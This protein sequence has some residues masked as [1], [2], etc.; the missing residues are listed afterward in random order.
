M[1]FINPK[2]SLGQHFLKD[3]N[4]AT[5]IINSIKYSDYPILEIGPGLGILTEG[6]IKNKFDLSVIEIDSKVIPL[7]EKKFPSLKNKIFHGDFLKFS[8]AKIYN[9]TYSIIGNFPYNI[10]SQ[11]FF[12]IYDNRNNIK[13]VVCMVQKEVAER[14]CSP[15]GSKKYGILSVLLQAFYNI[16]YLFTVSEKVFNPPPKVKS[17]VI[18]LERNKN[19]V[20]GCNEEL[21]LK[22]VKTGFNQRRKTLK[23]SLKSI[24]LNLG[25]E[26]EILLKR[27]EQLNVEEFIGLVNLIDQN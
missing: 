21:F 8:I 23:N 4:I 18:H 17:A 6:L 12:K 1:V 20:L 14:L 11:I 25:Q 24:L 7:L 15:A 19:K 13:E 9:K 16:D 3:K 26:N 2:K 27:P 10:S 22:V 5:K